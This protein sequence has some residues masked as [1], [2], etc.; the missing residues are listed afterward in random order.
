MQVSDSVLA[1]LRAS[2]GVPDAALAALLRHAL[3]AAAKTPLASD[4][5][6]SAFH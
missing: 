2:A 4:I 6:G 1:G 5:Y 3:A